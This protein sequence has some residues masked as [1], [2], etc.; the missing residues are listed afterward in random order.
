MNK[1]LFK[2]F[3][4]SIIFIIIAFG[5]YYFYYS[6][7]KKNNSEITYI[8]EEVTKD[9]IES[10]ILSTGVVQ[11]KNRL[12]I[13]SP[14]A[15]RLEKILI[16]EG[17]NVSKG[18]ILAWMSSLERAALLDSARAKGNEELKRWEELYKPVPIIAPING[19]I[20]LKNVEIGQTFTTNDSVFVMSDKLTVKA[21][22][23]ETD[24][25]QIILKQNAKIV[26]DAYPNEIITAIVDKIAYDAKTVNNVTTYIVEVLP[27]QIPTHMRSGMT[28]NV[29]F[30]VASKEDALVIPTEAIK[31]KNGKNFVLYKSNNSKNHKNKE[32]QNI[33]KEIITGIS[34][35]KSTEVISGLE[36]G[37]IILIADI[38]I[39]FKNQ[40][41]QSNN[42]FNFMPKR[43][44]KNKDK[45]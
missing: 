30:V 22:V 28:A 41:S 44:K 37:D 14:I 39:Q 15:G 33:E 11:P 13:K 3:L 1:K 34:D 21:Q 31:I 36:E 40:S 7:N 16:V 29:T 17:E 24:I 19:K 27:S 23:D 5:I 42:P 35:G 2:W 8:E 20:I 45:K 18:Q 25:S 10:T 4:F 12:E 26:L 32:Q 38:K 6:Y 9:S 43:S